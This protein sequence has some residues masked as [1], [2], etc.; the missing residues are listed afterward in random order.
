MRFIFGKRNKSRTLSYE[1]DVLDGEMKT[2]QSAIERMI[3]EGLGGGNT[4]PHV[5]A[6][7]EPV[8]SGDGWENVGKR[9]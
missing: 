6:S 4:D 7:L 2:T 1:P 9:R 3:D 8:T 5:N